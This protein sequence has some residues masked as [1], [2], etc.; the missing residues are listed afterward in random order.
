MGILVRRVDA[1]RGIMRDDPEA[2]GCPAFR[3]RAA[4]AHKDH[5]A[6]VIF[7]SIAVSICGGGAKVPSPRHQPD[8]IREGERWVLRFCVGHRATPA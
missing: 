7:D 4:L 6:M 3:C 1:R 2:L 8:A 5:I